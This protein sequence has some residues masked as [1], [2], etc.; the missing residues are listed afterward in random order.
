VKPSPRVVLFVIVAACTWVAGNVSAEDMDRAI[1]SKGGHAMDDGL[2]YLRGTLQADGSWSHSVGVTAL[3]LRAFM[4]N[5]RGYDETDG[6]YITRP[7][8]F[9]LGNVKD[10]GAISESNQNRAYNT[11]AAI[12]ALKD[13]KNPAYAQ[14]I[15]NAQKYL[16]DLQ[17]DEAD[18][19]APEHR[20]YGGI[21]YGD[22]ERPDLSNQYFALEAL[23]ATAFNPQDPVWKRALVFISRSQ[24]RSESNDQ[25]WAGN[26]GGFTY[27]PGYSPHGET[28]SYGTMTHAGLVSLL[29]AGVDKSDPRVQAAHDWIRTN[30]TVDENPGATEGAQALFYY[31]QVFGTCMAAY[32]EDEITDAK[33]I[34]HNWHNDLT[35]KVASMQ[36]KDGS[37]INAAS[38]RWWEDNR[39]LVTARA[40]IALNFAMK[41]A[42]GEDEEDDD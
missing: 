5:R 3:V 10:D 18:G 23:R 9:I 32:G 41:T 36:D 37:W 7:I 8:Q 16:A 34:K 25:S 40:L 13:T 27:M 42:D 15:A 12:I 14:V 35:A 6:P 29:F 38:P 11:S 26:D 1:R 2:H 19:Y 4:E 31:F 20:Y 17:I 39:D 33:G 28:N 22:D 21:G 30:Y 24:N